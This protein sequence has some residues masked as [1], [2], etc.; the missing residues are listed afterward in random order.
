MDPVSA[1]SVA[2][3][4]FQLAG[5]CV[6]V[7]QSLANLKSK[8]DEASRTISNIKRFCATI[9]LAARNIQK[10]LETTIASSGLP[11]PWL[12]AVMAALQD[13]TQ[14]VQ[15]LK[16]DID[17]ITGPTVVDEKKLGRRKRLLFV[18]N[19]DLMEQHLQQ[20]HYLSGALHLLLDATRL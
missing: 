11:V 18:W 2:G 6:S 1:L 10:W 16:N 5:L 20:L 14:V 8:Y 7:P 3:V 9:E 4:A 13:Y 19:Q 15:D 12:D 17:K